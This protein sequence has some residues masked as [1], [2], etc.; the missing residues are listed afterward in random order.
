MLR[1]RPWWG[2]PHHLLDATVVRAVLLPA[3]MQLLG[4]WNW[5]LPHWLGWLPRHTRREPLPA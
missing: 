3:A 4:E 2:R 1:D 5:Y